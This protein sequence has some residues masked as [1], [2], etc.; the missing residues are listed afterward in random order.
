VLRHY[1][2]RFPVGSLRGI[3]SMR[4]HEGGTLLPLIVATGFYAE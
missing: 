2:A 1:L 4:T 3:L